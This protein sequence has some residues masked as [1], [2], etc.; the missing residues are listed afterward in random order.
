MD[1]NTTAYAEYSPIYLSASL[2]ITYTIAYALTTAVVVHA[3]LWHGPRIWNGIR[4]VKTEAP[5]IH[6]KL[7]K[8]YPEV[9]DWWYGVV[10]VALFALG[11]VCIEAFETNLPV[12]AF[13]VA[14][15]LALVYYLPTAILYASTVQLMSV[16]LIAE[17]IPGYMLPGKPIAVMVR[18]QSLPAVFQH[19]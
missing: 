6:L 18:N 15:T 2:N 13:I 17:L 16:N 9:P 5:D 8:V 14:L 12:W 3:A 10:F 19:R 4:N 11:I 7:I 1:L